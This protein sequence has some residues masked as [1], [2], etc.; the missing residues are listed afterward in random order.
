[1]APARTM[2]ANRIRPAGSGARSCRTDAT[3]P[4]RG[5]V[6]RRLCATPPVAAAGRCPREVRERR[7]RPPL[8][9]NRQ[10]CAGEYAGGAGTQADTGAAAIGATGV[11]SAEDPAALVLPRAAICDHNPIAS[12]RI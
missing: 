2:P 12:G 8:A 11:A 5:G 3:P 7:Q 6:T 10:F 1:M 9:Y 4:V